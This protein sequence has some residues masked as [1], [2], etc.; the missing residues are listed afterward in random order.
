MAW[1]WPGTVLVEAERRFRR[2][3]AYRQIA[4]LIQALSKPLTE[5]RPL[6]IVDLSS[7]DARVNFHDKW[8]NLLQSLLAHILLTMIIKRQT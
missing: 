6:R 5:R 8:G 1:R 3:K 7:L 2:I 4:T